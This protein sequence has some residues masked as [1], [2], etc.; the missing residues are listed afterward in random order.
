MPGAFPKSCTCAVTDPLN[1]MRH[2]QRSLR[3]TGWQGFA[4]GIVG[5]RVIEIDRLQRRVP[6][7][8]D[9]VRFT[10]LDGD[11]ATGLQCMPLP[12][13]DRLAGA[14]H[15]V[16]PLIGTWVAIVWPAF[17]LA[18]CNHHFSGLHLA[19]RKQ[20]LERVGQC[21]L[22]NLHQALLRVEAMLRRRTSTCWQ[23]AQPLRQY[24]AQ[25]CSG[26]WCCMGKSN[27]R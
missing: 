8:A 15:H 12:L 25:M 4:L 9:L 18:W 20:H 10:A 2:R 27:A 1:D 6:G 21:Q 3:L 17:A 26:R 24:Q 5:G 14:V 11:Q 13:D 7:I 23:H 16:Q 22:C 19:H